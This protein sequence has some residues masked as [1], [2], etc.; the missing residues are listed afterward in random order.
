MTEIYNNVGRAV[1]KCIN[2]KLDI[3][4]APDCND[5]RN[6]DK[7]SEDEKVEKYPSSLE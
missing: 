5:S 6:Q 2:R 7:T 3:S 1:K 4:C